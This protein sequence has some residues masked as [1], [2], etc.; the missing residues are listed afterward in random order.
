MQVCGVVW[1]V[2]PADLQKA[3]RFFQGLNMCWELQQVSSLQCSAHF[4]SLHQVKRS[5]PPVLP[6]WN[7]QTSTETNEPRLLKRENRTASGHHLLQQ[8]SLVKTHSPGFMK[9]NKSAGKMRTPFHTALPI[10]QQQQQ[11]LNP[12]SCLCTNESVVWGRSK[13][14]FNPSPRSLM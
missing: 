8:S 11:Q 10:I 9:C 14:L 5:R 7:H 3:P 2:G 6:E 12:C 4:C 1:Y 13:T